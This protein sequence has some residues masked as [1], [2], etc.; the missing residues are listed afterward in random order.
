[1]LLRFGNFLVLIVVE[2]C[3]LLR[4]GCCRGLIVVEVGRYLGVVTDKA[5]LFLKFCKLRG[6]VIVDIWSLLRCV[7]FLSFGYG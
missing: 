5:R 2:V 1:M 7:W 6:L 4:L 3:F